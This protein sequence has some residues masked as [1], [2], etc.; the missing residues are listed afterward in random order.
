MSEKVDSQNTIQ[1]SNSSSNNTRILLV[2]DDA[3]SIEIMAAQFTQEGYQVLTAS[4]GKSAFEIAFKSPPDLIITDLLMPDLD[5]FGLCRRLREQEETRYIPVIIYTGVFLDEEDEKLGASLGVV[6][7]LLKPRD[8]DKLVPYV[9]EILNGENKTIDAEIIQAALDGRTYEEHIG[10][11]AYH[12]HKRFRQLSSSQSRLIE[13]EIRHQRLLESVPDAIVITDDKGI[14]TYVNKNTEALTGYERTE[15]LGQRVEMLIPEDKAQIHI[16]QRTTFINSESGYQHRARSRQKP[17]QLLVKSGETIPVEINLAQSDINERREITAIIR[18]V[19]ETVGAEQ[20][21]KALSRLYNTLSQCNQSLIHADSENEVLESFCLR[22]VEVGGF[23]MAWVGYGVKD[24]TQTTE[25]QENP[26]DELKVVTWQVSDQIRLSENETDSILNEQV[27]FDCN[28]LWHSDPI[29]EAI[30]LKKIQNLKL[31]PNLEGHSYW[32]HWVEKKL[33]FSGLCLPLIDKNSSEVLGVLNIYRGDQESFYEQEIN[34]LKELAQDLSFGIHVQ[35]RECQRQSLDKELLLYR[36][37]I[38]ASINGVILTDG[39]NPEH[40]I[41]FANAAFIKM[42]G[43]SSED[44]LG[45]NPRFLFGD[46]MEQEG[47]EELRLCLRNKEPAAVVVENYRKDGSLFWNDTR[48]APVFDENKQL[49]HYVGIANDITEQMGYQQALEY[50]S[51]YDGLTGLANRNLIKDRLAQALRM[52]K[53]NDLHIAVMFIDLDRFKQINDSLGHDSGD[54]LLKAIA[55]RFRLSLREEDS[56][57]RWG[58]D[59]F[60]IVVSDL[61][62]RSYIVSLMQKL[63]KIIQEPIYIQDKTL[64]ISGSIGCSLY[65]GD[66]DSPEQLMERADSAMYRA[67]ERGGDAYQFFSESMNTHVKQRFDLEMDLRDALKKDQFE[68]YYQPQVKISSGEIVGA[69]ALIRWQ[70]PEKGL[71]PPN[72]FIPIAEEVGLIRDIGAWVYQEAARQLKRWQELISPGFTMAVNV[73]YHQFTADHFPQDIHQTLKEIGVP[74]EQMELELTERIMMKDVD[75]ILSQLNKIKAMGLKISIDDFGTGYSSLSYLQHF[76]ADRLKIDRSFV[77]NLPDNQDSLALTLAIIR[78]AHAM[79][80]E[81][82]A[83]G[84]ENIKQLESLWLQ[85]CDL[86]QGYLFSRPLTVQAFESLLKEN[87]FVDLVKQ[88]S[89]GKKSFS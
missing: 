68:L 49:T 73:S 44:I 64:R 80:Y 69:E 63:L 23:A 5:G 36:R 50:Q 24:K 12:L 41:V 40:P 31:P 39:K 56:I 47:V 51:N 11:L 52:A 79:R 13:V 14:M 77:N 45:K 2:D 58:A 87:R 85:G 30:R 81:V 22:L 59:E 37:A 57:A 75:F 18:D 38:E 74:A 35:R 67:K 48:I 86:V 76:P 89:G 17:F 34:L 46:K 20:H 19:S 70:H 21:I 16:Q 15:L 9:I 3:V 88:M 26:F 28:D 32:Q 84:V 6:H 82:V 72:D 8:E 65:P 10:R 83:E 27:I 62:A 1:A 33:I 29:C 60:V 55:K 4:N 43:Y 42:T 78:M 7:Y 54:E 71:I 61:E 25:T 66:G 53:R